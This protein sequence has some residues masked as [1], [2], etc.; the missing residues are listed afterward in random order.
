[1]VWL[2]HEGSIPF[3]IVFH[4]IVSS[5]IIILFG[6][7]T[8]F[9]CIITIIIDRLKRRLGYVQSLEVLGRSV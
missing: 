7:S 6:F 5:I 1:M 8:V 2:I 9:I 4:F 3:V